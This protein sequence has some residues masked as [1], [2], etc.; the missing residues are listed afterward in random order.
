MSNLP[1]KQL[2]ERFSDQFAENINLAKHSAC[3][4]GGPADVLL[5]ASSADKLKEIITFLNE[6]KQ[7]FFILGGGSNVLISDK[8][9]RGIVVLNKAKHI[10]FDLDSQPP[11]VWAESGSNL[12]RI[13]KLAQ[14]NNLTGLEWASGIPGTIGGAIYGNAGAHGGEIAD[15][16]ISADI[17]LKNNKQYKWKNEDFNFE[18]R[19]SKLQKTNKSIILSSTFKLEHGKSEDI[20]QEMNRILAIR[21]KT[22]PPGASLGSIFKNPPED[23]SGRLID[24]AG[25]KGISI[26]NAEISPKHGNFFINLGDATGSDIS[27]LID[28][29]QKTVQEKFGIML[30]L[31]IKKIGE[32]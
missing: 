17:L 21:K 23:Y 25:L 19:S 5:T 13:A 28:L 31:E 4:I 32:W 22:Q 20:S 27:G 15:N 8:G 24:A 6:L 10:K 30:E 2:Q 7:E 26:G 16:L 11:S 3:R 14:E 12:I 1:I 29:V 9:I 18:Y